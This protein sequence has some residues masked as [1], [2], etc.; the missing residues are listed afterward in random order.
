MV[1]SKLQGFPERTSDSYCYP[2]VNVPKTIGDCHRHS[3]F[4]RIENAD[5]PW[6]CG[7][8][9]EK[10]A[11]VMIERVKLRRKDRHSLHPLRADKKVFFVSPVSWS[12]IS[13][14]PAATKWTVV[15]Y[16]DRNWDVPMYPDS[17]GWLG[18]L[19]AQTHLFPTE[20]GVFLDVAPLDL[21]VKL[22]MRIAC[23]V[24]VEGL[25]M[26]KPWSPA[27]MIPTQWT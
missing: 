19:G 8:F 10:F 11:K 5:V 12:T 9:A 7:C 24:E 20:G 6:W 3:E 4:S 16:H 2:P 21:P 23:V 25:N 26:L 27:D 13:S 18:W 22:A 15:R 14:I 17:L 1:K